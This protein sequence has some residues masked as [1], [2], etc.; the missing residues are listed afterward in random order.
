MTATTDKLEANKKLARDYIDQVFNQ[1]GRPR[2]V[3]GDQVADDSSQ[4]LPAA[5]CQRHEHDDT[6]RERLTRAARQQDI[7]RPGPPE[8]KPNHSA[9]VV[10][11]TRLPSCASSA[12]EPDGS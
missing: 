6:G 9:L 10:E 11:R 3:P 5:V 8:L 4:N 12:L 7:W 2:V 1:V